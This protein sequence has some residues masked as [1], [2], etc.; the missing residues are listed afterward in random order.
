MISPYGFCPRCLAPG[1]TRERR[2]NGNDRCNNGHT[3]LSSSALTKAP[4]L[5]RGSDEQLELSL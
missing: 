2:P 1:Y 5:N 4:W 3:Y